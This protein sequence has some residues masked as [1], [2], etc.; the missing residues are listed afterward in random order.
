L[1]FR[2]FEFVAKFIVSK[3][4]AKKKRER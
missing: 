1:T 3:K 2:V 4:S